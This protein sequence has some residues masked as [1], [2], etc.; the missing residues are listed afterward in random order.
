VKLAPIAFFVYKRPE[1]TLRA[2]EALSRCELAAESVLYIFCDGAK[3]PEDAAAV[4]QVRDVVAAR[5]WCG[6]VEIIESDANK[7][8]ACSIIAGV[9]RLCEEYGRVIVLEDDLIVSPYFLRY[10]NDALELYRD[11]EMVMQI[12]GYMFDAGLK[13]ESDAIFL[14]LPTSWG[15]GVWQRTWSKFDAGFTGYVELKKDK[16]L[17]RKFNLD[18]KANYFSMLEKSVAGQL[19]SWAIKWYLFVFMNYGLV[20]H[21]AQSLVVNGGF[22]GSGT[23]C[24]ELKR[25]IYNDFTVYSVFRF[26]EKIV[27]SEYKQ[28]VYKAIVG[29]DST[30]V[31]KKIYAKIVKI[32]SGDQ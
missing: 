17:R 2:L 20:L 4:Q 29:V 6:T 8:L 26:P 32:I 7:G 12:S 11:E 9:G 23:H 16:K 30:S 25:S 13:T 3:R 10:M 19:D 31:V 5:Q 27:E 24:G 14:P 1:H 22:D 28:L 15:W 21:P 18:G